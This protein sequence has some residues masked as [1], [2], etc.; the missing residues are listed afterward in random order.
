[1][2]KLVLLFSLIHVLVIVNAQSLE[3]SVIGSAGG[4]VTSGN[5]TLSFTVGE[6]A[7]QTLISGNI[8]LT[9]G[10]QQPINSLMQISGTV[11]YANDVSTAL[12]ALQLNL[13][14][15]NNNVVQSTMTD[16]TGYYL[17]AGITPGEYTIATTSVIAHGGINSTD[18]LLVQQHQIMT[19]TLEG[20]NLS[21][22]DVNLSNFV[23]S[24]DGLLV[25]QR[26]IGVISNFDS[27]DWL[28]ETSIID[29]TQGDV[30]YDYIGI[31]YGDV[32]G[33]YIPGQLRISTFVV[34]QQKEEIHISSNGTFTIPFY[35][36]ND[37]ELNAVSLVMDLP[38][39]LLNVID[40][41]FLNHQNKETMFNVIGNQLRI[42]WV[43]EESVILTKGDLLFNLEI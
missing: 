34:I 42:S 8:I 13:V 26:F 29:A 19:D 15:V 18:A 24:S 10:F 25:R 9:E 3:R 22:G 1:M 5:I 16:A 21:A 27:G 39:E 33:S 41:K 28:F 11:A 23:N 4:E 35:V 40:V 6:V 43:G 36:N 14:D 31:C 38:I 30:T 7:V 37:I 12:E 2:K 32:N 20:L 17:F